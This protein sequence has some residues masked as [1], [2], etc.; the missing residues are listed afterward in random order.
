MK[1]NVAHKFGKGLTPRQFVESMTKNQQAFES[2]YE[3]FTWEDES[4]KEYFESLNH[5]DDLR[6]LILA[7]DW[8]GDVVRNVPAVF[9]ILETAGMKTEVFILE[10]NL[11]LMDNFLTMGGRSVPV[12]IFA[13]TGGYVLGHWGPRPERVQ[14]I[15]REFKREN[16]DREAADYDSKIAEARKAMGQAYGEGTEYQAVIAKE[17]RSLISGF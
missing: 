15:M 1:Q 3:K 7:A 17:L 11:E 4:D 10:E 8:C 14:S 16:P 5:R 6:V 9:R 13:D 2:W 12:V